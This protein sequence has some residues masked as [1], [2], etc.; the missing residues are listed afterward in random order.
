MAWWGD[1]GTDRSEEEIRRHR[2]HAAILLIVMI[3]IAVMKYSC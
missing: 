2:W 3:L 1:P